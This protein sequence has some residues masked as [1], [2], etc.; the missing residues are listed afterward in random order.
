MSAVDLYGLWL[1][2][3]GVSETVIYVFLAEGFEEMEAIAPI[4]LL[5]RAGCAVQTVAVGPSRTVTGSHGIPITADI[6]ASEVT[7][8]G[9]EAVILPGGMPGT[10]HL[11][12]DETVQAM[13]DH[14]V[15]A[16]LVLG[17]ICAA[18][19]ILGHKGLLEGK[20]AVCFPGFEE[21]L[22]GAIVERSLVV[23]DDRVV[24]AKGA[25][26]ATEFGLALV[27]LLVS[28]EKARELREGI[29]CK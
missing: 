6:T 27:S 21:A 8:D 18:P 26:A 3:K 4:D 15:S 25:G 29:Q 1:R 14:A 28:P 24:T 9:L 17:A 11:E 22:A 2:V 16:R 19:S 13:I 12:A 10:L 23:T 20:R 5:R 7:T